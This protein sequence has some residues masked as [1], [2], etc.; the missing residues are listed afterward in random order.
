MKIERPQRFEI[1][2]V[3]RG[4]VIL[5]QVSVRIQLE[6]EVAYVNWKEDQLAVHVGE[7]LMSCTD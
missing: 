1:V 5:V 4:F 6:K 3:A 7:Q 2:S